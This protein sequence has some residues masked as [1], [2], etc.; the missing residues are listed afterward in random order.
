MSNQ[1]RAL[2][3]DMIRRIQA[4]VTNLQSPNSASLETTQRLAQA[5]EA[6]RILLQRN[7]FN[8]DLLRVAAAEVQ[9]AHA[10]YRNERNRMRPNRIR[11]NLQNRY[12]LNARNR[13]ATNIRNMNSVRRRANVSNMNSVRRRLFS[14]QGSSSQRPQA[15]W[16]NQN[17]VKINFPNR[18]LNNVEPLTQNAYQTNRNYAEVRENGRNFYFSFPNFAEWYRRAGTNPLTRKRVNT[19]RKV[20]FVLTPNQKRRNNAARVIQRA[21]RRR[22]RPH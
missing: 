15:S 21:F 3:N 8:F 11:N 1:Q 6:L 17:A 14:D 16:M 9:S 18:L 22:R 5:A 7:N 19:A 20:Q 13:M 10:A 12:S 2:R 4:I